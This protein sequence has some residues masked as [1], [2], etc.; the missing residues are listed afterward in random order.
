[1]RLLRT[2]VWST[3]A[4]LYCRPRT[5]STSSVS[6]VS[7]TGRA[8]RAI[9]GRC[10]EPSGKSVIC[11]FQTRSSHIFPSVVARYLCAASFAWRPSADDATKEWVDSSSLSWDL[12]GGSWSARIS[13]SVVMRL[14]GRLLLAGPLCARSSGFS[15]P[16]AS[17]SLTLFPRP[18]GELFS[19]P[20]S[21]A[22]ATEQVPGSTKCSPPVAAGSKASSFGRTPWLMCPRLKQSSWTRSTG[23]SG[24]WRLGSC[25]L[26]LRHPRFLCRMPASSVAHSWRSGQP[27]VHA[28]GAGR[29]PPDWSA[30]SARAP[31]TPEGQVVTNPWVERGT[32]CPGGG[33]EPRLLCFYKSWGMGGSRWRPCV[34]SLGLQRGVRAG[35]DFLVRAL[36]PQPRATLVFKSSPFVECGAAVRDVMLALGSSFG[37]WGSHWRSCL[38]TWVCMLQSRSRLLRHPR[39]HTRRWVRC[40]GSE[41]GNG[42]S[43]MAFS[44]TPTSHMPF[45]ATRTRWHRLAP[46]LRTCP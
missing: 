3:R 1:M 32:L 12:G 18:S 4:I 5:W 45:A 21:I 8:G 6:W 15:D 9:F 24:H 20:S 14:G 11:Q 7:S 43:N 30:W 31:V 37:R 35:A 10:G 26:P 17:W 40:P 41:P 34:I 33:R 16:P 44:T 28:G 42:E 46:C 13:G 27:Q 39:A 22:S 2:C 29:A 19:Q 36:H 38:A 25:M 23:R